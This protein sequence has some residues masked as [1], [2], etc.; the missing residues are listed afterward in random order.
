MKI[1]MQHIIESQTEYCVI[2]KEKKGG[3]FTVFYVDRPDDKFYFAVC[4]DCLQ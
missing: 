2:C 1:T 4:R 3:K